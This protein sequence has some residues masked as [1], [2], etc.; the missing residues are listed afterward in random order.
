VVGLRFTHRR[1]SFFAIAL[2]AVTFCN[3]AE[4]GAFHILQHIALSVTV[5]VMTLAYFA[6]VLTHYRLP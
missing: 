3:S 1:F 5:A 2:L 6:C 4:F